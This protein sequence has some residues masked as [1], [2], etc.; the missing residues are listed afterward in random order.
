M[1][2]G[3]RSV[4]VNPIALLLVISALGLSAFSTQAAGEVQT[5]DSNKS[6]D[7]LTSAE[8]TAAK[9][10]ARHKKLDRLRVCADPGNLP[11]SN[12]KG[13]GY[14][15]KIIEALARAMDTK[16]VYFW[17]P[18]FEQGLA[19][20]VFVKDQCDLLLD[21]PADYESL[22]T[23]NPIYRTTYVFASREDSNIRIKDFDDPQLKTLRL[24]AF[25]HS[26]MRLA[27]AQHG[28]TQNVQVHILSHRADLAP[29]EQPWRQVQEVLD[30]KLDIAAV[31][32]PFAGW[33]KTA[34]GEPLFIQPVNL[35]DDK[36]QLEF[37]LAHAMP[38]N[39]VV[40]KYM[41]DDALER[42]KDEIK[43]ILTDYGV[44]LVQCSNCVVT[45]D[46][47]SH[48]S[49]FTNRQEV[50]QRL[51]LEPLS[52]ARTELNR[53]QA[54]ADQ[55]VT[56]ERLDNWLKEGANLSE[57]LSNAV[58]ASDH[59]RVEALL[60]KGADVN[61]RNL[62][63]FAPI[64]TAARQR[65]S[66]MIAL[67]V[68]HGADV[69]E[70]DSEGWTPLLH[71]AFR[72][73][74]PSVEVL[75]KGGADLDAAAPGGFT[76]LA[77]AIEEGK[78]FAAKALI[79][80]GAKADTRLGKDELTPLMVVASKPQMERRA[81]SLNQGPSSVEIAKLLIAKGA[82]VNARSKAGVT[83]LMVAA[84]YDNAVLA[85]V[86]IQSGADIDAKTASGKTALD[87]AKANQNAAAKQQIE[88]L[89][90]GAAKPSGAASSP[91]ATEPAA[92]Q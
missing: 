37:S 53:K 56:E 59:A 46:I 23:T 8:K 55:V 30:G 80:S 68:Q 47:P 92:G 73:H 50:A 16:V 66:D 45:G 58:V 91:S 31:W 4:D 21:F 61:K 6:F 35:M 76:P 70:P 49:Y 57:E 90:R 24:G 89:M 63:G 72:N 32:G 75:V 13:E 38:K 84:T 67:L 83:P 15:N 62:Q 22:L 85:G 64:H 5:Y 26:G 54:T 34:K 12:V 11:L 42:S 60:A 69:N 2:Q 71:A 1:N 65:D 36:M 29:E 17:R 41:L 77:I 51:F 9:T 19:R 27:L 43:Q 10:A 78:F 82:D 87:I 3:P 18:Y 25:Q 39:S 52:A 28:V 20:E 81:Q 44:P 40:L 14:E 88:L 48:G 33:L 86:L 74:V 7:E 79:D